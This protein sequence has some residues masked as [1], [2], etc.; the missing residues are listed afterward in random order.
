MNN[1]AGSWGDFFEFEI[2]TRQGAEKVIIDWDQKEK[3]EAITRWGLHKD[4]KGRKF[5]RAGKEDGQV[6]LHRILVDVPK[7]STL[8][9]KNGNTLDCRRKNLQLV[10][11][12]GNITELQPQKV[13]PPA[14]ATHV[15]REVAKAAQEVAAGTDKK[16]SD[17]KGVYFHKASQRWHASAFHGGKRYS[18]GYFQ[19]RKD[20]ELEVQI[21]REAGPDHPA[22]KRNHSKGDKK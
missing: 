22:L 16:T 20:A 21:F 7:G 10:D 13:T 3:A 6:L 1:A 8:V 2:H 12:D 5:A 4:R 18:L 11:K 9:W 15:T 19:E 14:Y 17:V